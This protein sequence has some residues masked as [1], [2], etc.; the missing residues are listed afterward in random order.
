MIS[1]FD[2]TITIPF[3]FV[4]ALGMEQYFC[5]IIVGIKKQ[6]KAFVNQT[7]LS[8]FKRILIDPIKRIFFFRCFY[9]MGYFVLCQ[10][11]ICTF[12]ENLL[13]GHTFCIILRVLCIQ[14]Y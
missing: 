3:E 10:T 4:S 5:L 14:F 2:I 1:A 13:I 9:Y 11:A 12:V 6:T 7:P 8:V